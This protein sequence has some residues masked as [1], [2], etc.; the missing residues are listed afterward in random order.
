MQPVTYR[1][2]K[3]PPLLDVL[4]LLSLGLFVFPLLIAAGIALRWLEVPGTAWIKRLGP[5]AVTYFWIFLAVAAIT[6]VLF[7]LTLAWKSPARNFL[8]LDDVGLTYGFLG[9]RR[10][11]PWRR[12]QSAEVVQTGIPF[13]AATLKI[14]GTFGWTD[15][16]TLLCLNAL[17]SSSQA[18][19]PLPDFYEAPI[20]EIVARIKACRSAALGGLD[21]AKAA[22]ALENGAA[23]AR[24]AP[25]TFAKSTVIYRRLRA[26]QFALL[27]M[28]LPVVT[29]SAYLVRL[30]ENRGWFD[31]WS[32]GAAFLGV[33]AATMVIVVV[34]QNR[35][36]LPKYNNLRLDD[37]GLVYARLG[38]PWRW[39]WHELSDFTLHVASSRR[40]L[41]RRRFITFAAPGRDWTWLWLRKYYGLPNR[42]RLVLIEDVYETA[43]DEIADTLNAYREQALAG[44][45]P[46]S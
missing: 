45:A 26:V 46:S 2:V 43:L 30:I 13:R 36:N 44:T 6:G 1:F 5:D 14:S 12:V 29:A 23:G 33:A 28:T 41:G 18:T 19:L 20:E 8:L 3:S 27:A 39:R 40:L 10:R 31:T 15:R 38:R 11:W 42:P 4:S 34:L 25:L 24:T 7:V 16:L 9:L 21:P 17:A 22:G 35:A 32:L 37:T